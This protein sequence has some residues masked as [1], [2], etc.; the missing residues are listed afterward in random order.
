MKNLVGYIG[1]LCCCFFP[2]YAAGDNGGII[3][4]PAVVVKHAGTFTFDTH[5]VILADPDTRAEC[6][7]LEDYL[8]QHLHWQQAIQF[9]NTAANG[10]GHMLLIT[11]QGADKLP[12]GGYRLLI[13]GSRITLTGKGAGLF[14][15]I[16][17]LIQLFPVEK[18]S[19]AALPC[20]E[21]VD[22]PRFA[23][24]G[25]MLDV[26]R[27]FFSVAEVKKVIDLMARYKLNNFHW[28]L[29]DNQGWRIAIKKYPRLTE[30][31]AYRW[32]TKFHDNRDWLD[33]VKYGG[34][35][36]AADIREVVAY[37]AQ[38][39]INII[40]EIEMPGHSGAALTAYPALKCPL[41]A[42]VKDSTAYQV[43]YRP[44]EETFHFLEDI[45]SEVAELFP[46]KYIHVGGDEVNHTP[47]MQDSV[48]QRLI[49]TQQLKDEH[50]LQSYFIQRIGQFLRTKGK[51][52]IGWDE[53]VAGGLPPGA[54]VMS[55]RNEEG[56]IAAALQQHPVIMSSEPNGMYFDVYQ[57]SADTEPVNRWGYAPLSLTYSYDPVPAVLPEAARRCIWGVQANIWTEWIATPA[58]LQYMI[59]PRM[60]ALA[61]VAWSPVAQKNFDRFYH[62]TVPLHL[63]RLEQEGLNYKVPPAMGVSDT[64]MI[65]HDFT[66]DLAATIPGAKI[67]YTLNGRIP[68]DTDLEY[69]GPLH[70]LVPENEKRMLRTL[71]ITPAGRRSVATRTV[72]YNRLPAPPV[73]VKDIRPGIRYTLRNGFFSD[74]GALEC[75][76]VKERG[77]SED[78][79]AATFRKYGT[80][81]GLT[82]DGWLRIDSTGI[83]NFSLASVASSKL[84]IDNEIV[85]DN[86]IPHVRFE[87]TGAM[88]LMKGFHRITLQYIDTAAPKYLLKVVIRDPANKK[89]DLASLLYHTADED[90]LP[91]VY[92]SIQPD[93]IAAAFKSAAAARAGVMSLPGDAQRWW[94]Y[95]DSLKTKII[96]STHLVVD[97]QLPLRM[98]QTG[99]LKK[100]GYEIRNIFFQTRPGVYATAT[101]FVPDGKGPF[102][103]VI[104]MS[105][106][107][108]NG[109]LYE[110]YQAV[111]QVLALNGYVSLHI[112]PWGA[113]ERTTTHGVFEYHGANRG[114]SLMDIGETLMGMQLTD[115]IRGVDLLESLPFVDR[116]NI[117]AT[118]ASGG[119]N[120][121]M[122]L[123]A[124]DE[125]IK[126]AV[127][128]VSVG[129]FESY[130]M[131]SNCVCELLPDGLTY[132]EEAALLAM[133]AP[134]A[135]KMCNGNKDSNPTFYPSEMLRS[136][137]KAH[138]VFDML[139]VGNNISYQVFDLPH[140]YEKE[141]REA[142]LGW[143][144]LHLKR[145]GDGSPVAEDR[146]QPVSPEQLMTFAAN[147]RDTGV[148]S[149]AAFCAE[150]G[151]ALH[152]AL[153][154]KK[155]IDAA[156]K[157]QDLQQIL[158]REKNIGLKSLDTFPR[159]K[160][161]DRWVLELSEGTRLP[162]LHQSPS[163]GH[164]YT[165]IC[166]PGG[167]DSIDP[168]LIHEL[169]QKGMGIIVID[170]LGTGENNSAAA[171]AFDARLVPFHTLSRTSLWLGK[172]IIGQWMEEL[173][174][175]IQFLKQ[176]QKA[177]NIS[178]DGTKE[179]GLAALFLS[180]L[181]RD[182]NQV[183]LRDAPLSYQLQT[184]VT[185]YYS[186]AI[187][188]P[189]IIGWGDVALAA[190]MS[191][192]RTTFVHPR[193][194]SGELT[195]DTKFHI[196]TAELKK[197]LR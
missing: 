180:A 81:F 179:T 171:A 113:G 142:M 56:G 6:R 50:G 145:V 194:I 144:N 114:A 76:T 115:N 169:E 74:M 138:P 55:W 31:G 54:V 10:N 116:K 100:R 182:V 39:Y 84:S 86:T 17:S 153:L 134:R 85:A 49:R 20:M 71:V 45:L 1:W 27:H 42:G 78:V 88:P 165:I 62:Q 64:T 80:P 140:G 130:V 161:W 190:A 195:T 189:G 106:H 94:R 175:T 186:M 162:L 104:T 7:F 126:A 11:T 13:S 197:R 36:T 160:G 14:Y 60:L 129:T 164:D 157:R 46:G 159:V 15:G 127:P 16:Q 120:Q 87:R 168:A 155:F 72:M 103:A 82:Y 136:F 112:D 29:T 51:Q 89:M 148:K 47:W 133:V 25:L 181:T 123:A 146:L 119:G 33:S 191:Y 196:L 128:V 154:S 118:G 79:D 174:V 73:T 101:L 12:E 23:Y 40:P 24:R 19:T 184:P 187:H 122:Y 4:A 163:N 41:P 43:V 34:F 166:N 53:I 52:L 99:T 137:Q 68:D 3:P 150:Q 38:R 188:L 193:T 117:G 105:G 92:D 75:G 147:R 77:V 111:G 57:S 131:Q 93:R 70:F 91:L 109:R 83:Y 69:T 58:K 63:A 44:T 156:A 67:Y 37:A 96:Q 143:F 110:K 9:R 8:Q 173:Q 48:S 59:L 35:Y 139:G 108:P 26:A 61:E 132:T 21:I 90:V 124:M 183:V 178:I 5:T 151:A 158:R 65:G 98:Q 30:T 2:L 141:D 170:L 167:K 66:F 95:R 176:H 185:D 28:H 32:L 102:P 107:S 121:T 97:H 135:I 149:T 152:Q 192:A 18:G 172:T 177:G 22:Q 125:R